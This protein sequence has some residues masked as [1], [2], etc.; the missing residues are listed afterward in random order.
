MKSEFE[1]MLPN[2]VKEAI[3]RMPVAYMPWGALEWHGRHL[4]VG[5]DAIK[6]HELCLRIARA[7][8]GG[9]VFPPSFVSYN[10]V[11]FPWTFKY[12]V[13]VV[14]STLWST[15]KQLDASG[16]R[17]ILVITG[18]YPATQVVMF[19]TI[20]EL[21]MFSHRAAVVA[22]PEF[23]AA[24]EKGYK[25]DH[26]AKWETSILMYLFPELVDINQL[27]AGERNKFSRILHDGVMGKD[28]VRHASSELGK[29][30]V[31]HIV[32][33]FAELA[34]ELARNPDKKIARRFH[35]A[36]IRKLISF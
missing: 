8:G 22:C 33:H 30:I 19:I 36:A 31:D 15:L 4:P 7:A 5:L 20:A 25:G 28:P 3:A 18:H 10:T 26:A 27:H 17:A 24:I 29:E 12:P 23:F 35:R 9:V 1:K 21:F 32:E 11:S 13:S 14:H 34:R 16:F 2:E 6:A